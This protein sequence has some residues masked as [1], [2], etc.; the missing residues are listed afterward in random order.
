MNKEIFNQLIKNPA[1]VNPKY[2]D[3]LK[4]LVDTFPYAT[5]IRLLYLSSLLNDA[6]V[7]FEQELKKTA[8]YISDRRI[9][10][11]II[12]KT[13][14]KENYIIQE[15]IM[16]VVAK[17]TE[18]SVPDNDKITTQ[19]EPETKNTIKSKDDENNTTKKPKSLNESLEK[20]KDSESSL[21]KPEEINKESNTTEKNKSIT[22]LDDLIVSSA[23]GA[24]ISLDIDVVSTEINKEKVEENNT[25]KSFLEWIKASEAKEIRPELNPKQ[26]ERIE[27][28]ERA[29]V[30]INQFIQN[31]PK[32]KPKAEFYSAENMAKKSIEDSEEIV[33]ETLAKVYAAQGNIVKAKSIYNQ[34]IL[35]NPEKKSYF[36]SLIN[37]LRS[38]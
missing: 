24:S 3:N 14:P 22:E 6:D 28:K 25:P 31:Q 5:N 35:K 1:N 16:K 29:E 9:L 17:E 19:K 13:P 7:L 36:A 32:I 27:F 2:K 33:T 37:G 10:K 34:L 12:S 8:A 30:L 15:P 20:V 11:Q 23:I 4:T 26:K 21:K 38:E 18:N